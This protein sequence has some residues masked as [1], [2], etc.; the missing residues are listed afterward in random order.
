MGFA[1]LLGP[2][3]QAHGSSDRERAV[4]SEC[5]GTSPIVCHVDVPPGN[6]TVS[7]LLGGST[8]GS[9]SVLVEARRTM[10]AETPTQAGRHAL[11]TFTVNVREP[12]G[13]PTDPTGTP[14][15]DIRFEGAAPQLSGLKVTPAHRTPQILLAGDSTVCDQWYVPYA[16]W[17]QE[18]TQFLRRGI[19]VANYA[20]SGEST[21]SFLDNPLLFDALEARIRRG[22]LVLIQLAHN[23]KTT[24]AAAY[25]ANLTAMAER[26]VAQGGRPVFVTP[27]VRRRFNSDGTLNGVALHVTGQ[28]D[29]PAEM[30]SLAEELDVPLVDLTAMSQELVERLGPVESR[31]L[32][33]TDVNGDNT[34]T[35]VH[36]A[37]RY[38]TLVVGALKDQRLI[39]SRLIR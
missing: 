11:R 35:S 34:H 14:G 21:Q 24:T 2:P 7:A 38:A 10:L 27:I 36:G 19:S 25:R 8:P 29:L 17:G 30:R 20:D 31:G 15:L 37:T 5:S 22:D 33:L 13:Q 4:P 16:G 39:P 26:V 32:Y 6:Y 1:T 12:E 23:D 18:L 28:A 9:T 3:A